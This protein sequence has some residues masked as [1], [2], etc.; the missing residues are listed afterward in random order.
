LTLPSLATGVGRS[1]ATETRLQILRFLVATVAAVILVADP[2]AAYNLAPH[3]A[4]SY[5][6]VSPHKM[7]TLLRRLGVRWSPFFDSSGAEIS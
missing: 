1:R 5:S 7:Q 6:A 4:I 3:D 2:V